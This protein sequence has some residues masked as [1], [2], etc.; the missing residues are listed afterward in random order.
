MRRRTERSAADIMTIAG[1]I[2]VVFLTLYFIHA[3]V[4]ATFFAQ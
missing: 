4:F 3:F 1:L 2:V